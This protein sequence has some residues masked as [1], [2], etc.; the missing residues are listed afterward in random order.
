MKKI[1]A[2]L[3]CLLTFSILFLCYNKLAYERAMFTA[4]LAENSKVEEVGAY[5]EVRIIEVREDSIL[6]SPTQDYPY[7]FER[8]G[9]YEYMFYATDV[10]EI[11]LEDIEINCELFVGN[12]VRIAYVYARGTTGTD[13]IHLNK[14]ESIEDL[15][16]DVHWEDIITYKGRRF[17]KMQLS[18]ETIQWLELSEEEKLNSAYIPTDL[19]NGRFE[20]SNEVLEWGVVAEINNIT[21]TGLNI[22]F[23]GTSIL[24]VVGVAL[25]TVQQIESQLVMRH[26]KGFLE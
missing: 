25:E 16:D 9:Y 13:P 1:F 17:D 10:L 3:I 18:A 15:G 5:L 14:V 21:S 19:K 12:V 24:I 23:G 2:F 26:Y 11:S 20:M 7:Y 4:G 8:V 22:S 6:V